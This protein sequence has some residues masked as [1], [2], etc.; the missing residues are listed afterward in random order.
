MQKLENELYMCVSASTS[1]QL[2][3]PWEHALASLLEG[4]ESEVEK[5]I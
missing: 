3:S 2:P 4:R 1:A 5:N